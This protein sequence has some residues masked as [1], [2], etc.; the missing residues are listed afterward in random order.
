[1]STRCETSLLA[2]IGR[3]PDRGQVQSLPGE[4]RY[5]AA[6]L[7]RRRAARGAAG[8][9]VEAR[10]ARI[11]AEGFAR[12]SV[13]PDDNFFD[14]G[15]NSLLAAGFLTQVAEEFGQTLSLD[16][17]LERPTVRLLAELLRNSLGRVAA[18]LVVTIQTGQSGP[19]LF[20]LPGIGGNVLEFCVLAQQLGPVPPIYAVPSAGLD[21]HETPY[22]T[23][24]EM[25]AHAIRQ[26]RAIQ[27]FG[28]YHL[29]GYSLGGVVAFEAALQLQAAGESTALL[30]IIDSQLWTPPAA[31]SIAQRVRLHLCNLV[32]T[33]NRG[34][35][36][37]LCTRWRVAMERLRRKDLRPVEEDLVAGLDLSPASRKVARVHWHAWRHYEPRVYD[38]T[39]TLFVAQPDPSR[40]VNEQ[41]R[42]DVT[43]GWSRWTTREV[44]LHQTDCLHLDMLRAEELT[45][46]T[47]E[48]RGQGSAHD[49]EDDCRTNLEFPQHS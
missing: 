27:P 3:P 38:G 24:S 8:S 29:A 46:L 22:E 18:P 17:L 39:I 7:D 2:S 36:Q 15:G 34:R 23:I 32:H 5:L 41:G 45:V 12:E 33:T 19:P 30:A 47:S 6:D 42:F 4:R 13:G 26:M 28:P 35:W 48:L 31:L 40:S 9:A 49:E 20:C 14:L 44:K 25:A 43:L 1:M 16:V 11:L 21:D 37:Y 10:L